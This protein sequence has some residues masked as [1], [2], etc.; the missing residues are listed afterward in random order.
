MPKN[1]NDATFFELRLIQRVCDER[2]LDFNY[3]SDLER[4][5]ALVFQSHGGGAESKLQIQ[6][7]R[8]ES[9]IG[10][11][12][13]EM[14]LIEDEL[15]ANLCSLEWTGRNNIGKRVADLDLH[16]D[17]GNILP[18]SVKSGGP[19]TERN[20]GGRSLQELIG[21]KSSVAIKLMQN[22]T[23]KQLKE[24][25]P[26]INYGNSWNSIRKAI[27]PDERGRSMRE[28]AAVVGRK[29]QTIISNEI[30][31]AWN[32]S[33][34]KQKMLLLRYLALQNDERDVG[35]RIF[36]AEDDGAYF[37]EIVDVSSLSANQLSLLPY[38]DSDKG[39][40]LFCAEGD[41]VWRLNVNFTNG[42]G[43]SPIAIRVFAA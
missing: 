40:L 10:R 11:F 31:E 15:R 29:F 42:L 28:V 3:S 12:L 30:I 36:I 21:Y 35:L 7:S 4:Y 41:P 14:S 9:G 22:E 43:L 1:G 38:E 25:F 19:G 39:T 20:L 8:L 32:V 37:K 16:F 33:T 17:S 6:E 13:Q 5:R 2:D 27:S 24:A 23:I 26:G 18:L 34:N